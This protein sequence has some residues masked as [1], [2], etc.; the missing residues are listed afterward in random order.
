M[1]TSDGKKDWVFIGE[2]K[3]FPSGK[4]HLELGSYP[5]WGDEPEKP[6]LFFRKTVVWIMPPPKPAEFP[7]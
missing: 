7:T 3:V 6:G 1:T 2:N 5:T 4:S